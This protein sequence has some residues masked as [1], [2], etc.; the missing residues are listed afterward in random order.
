MSV[1]G[2]AAGRHSR[3]A[4]TLLLAGLCMTV[5]SGC[6]T[7]KDLKLLR[8][9]V[10]AL[11]SRQDSLF[12]MQDRN[13]R[14]LL[15]TVRVSFDI[16]RDAAGQTSHRFLQLEDQLSRT[17]ELLQQMQLL[18]S[19]LLGRLDRP[20]QS[21][22]PAN[23]VNPNPTGGTTGGTGV[24]GG[25]SGTQPVSAREAA[26]AYES[27]MKRMAEG[28][29]ST[30][31]SAFL[32]I[33]E[34]HPTDSI[35]PDAQFQVGMTYKAEANPDQA[36]AAFEKVEANWPQSPRAREALL[37]ACITADEQGNRDRARTFAETLQRRYPG[38]QE[39]QLARQRVGG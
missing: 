16:Q 15:D 14:L 7:K 33:L 29:F 35:A 1:S 23:P 10:L 18:V 17:E 5:A 32:F 12:R 13:Y 27:G 39:A 36:I 25:T 30:A 37:Q 31:R 6:A 21:T 28:A 20:V 8:E 2:R 24:T 22:V 34:E 4:A 11:Q 3:R 19:D 9:E 38:S 26:D